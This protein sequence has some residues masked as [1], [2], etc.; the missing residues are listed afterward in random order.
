MEKRLSRGDKGINPLDAA[1]KDHDIAYMSK[2]SSDRYDADK[3]L[4]K[5]A[6]KRLIAKDAS[7]GERA[8]AVG[9]A[10]SMKAKRLLTKKGKGLKTKTKTIRKNKS[11][12]KKVTFN[13]LIKNAKMVIKK[14]KP[15]TIR[16]AI[17]VA[18]DS[19]KQ[20]KKKKS[21]TKPRIIKVPT[22]SGG[23]LPLIPIFAGLSALGSI[24]GGASG[25]VNTI[26]QYR[27]AQKQLEENKRH[28]NMLEAI[29][30]GNHKTG[31][32]FYLQS[33]NTGNGFF[34]AAH[35]KKL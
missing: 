25:I 35:P 31:K 1:C 2:N 3:K 7:L 8:T 24:A 27:N 30:I 34:L 4:Q 29:A 19:V 18:V 15:T 17:E 16:S 10:L 5:A 14:S 23:I 28:N 21:V 20:T 26:N 13:T 6:M 22:H 11:K 32:G 9:V 12:A 33:S